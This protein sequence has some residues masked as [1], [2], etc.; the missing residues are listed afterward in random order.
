M[1]RAVARRCRVRVV[2]RFVLVVCVC[3]SLV[4]LPS[5]VCLAES[6]SA[7]EGHDH[8]PR[9]VDGGE[10]RGQ[11]ADDPQDFTE[12]ALN[13]NACGAPGL[14]QNHGLEEERGEEENTADRQPAGKKCYKGDGHV[15]PK[16]ASAP[17]ILLEMH[18]VKDRARA[19]K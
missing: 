2:W 7:P 1:M 16:P 17:Q 4:G 14:P 6:L 18:T 12:A 11:S 9:H 5:G 8:Q 3:V 13:A 19:E 15:F 10:Q